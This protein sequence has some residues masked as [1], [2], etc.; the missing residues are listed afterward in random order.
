MR[1]RA[2]PTVLHVDLDAFFASVEQ[3]DDP[4]L[5]GRPVIVGGLGDR[6]VVATASYEARRYGVR[7][8]MP[9]ARA[10]RACPDA[11]FVSPRMQ[12]YA[13]KSRDVMAILG[14]V[15][16]LVEQLS[17][18][19][20]FLDV[21]GAR[22]RLGPPTEIAR[23]VRSR[24]RDETGLTVSVGIATTKF[25]AKVASDL[26]KP[27][28]LLE[29]PAGDET[30]FLAPLPLARLWGAG[31]ATLRKCDRLGLRTIGDLA[32]L[33]EDVV[34]RALGAAQGA[35]L[36]ALAHN[37]D[38]RPVEPRRSAKSVGAEETFGTDLSSSR[39]CERELL[40]LADRVGGRLR[41]AGLTARTVTLKIRFADFETHTRARTLGAPT[42]VSATL[43]DTA[44]D[45]LAAFD[46]SRGVRLL[47]ISCSQFGATPA[48]QGM[49]DL[50]DDTAHA[51]ERTVR[52]AA[53]ER[54]V[55]GV[56]A[57]FGTAAVRPATLVEP[58]EAPAA[59]APS[60][61]PPSAPGAGP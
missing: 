46:T 56:R 48:G 13:Q 52:H 51:H 21:A 42:D 11:V 2:E 32:A 18:D 43:L 61:R 9:M 47:G 29:V 58:R 53:V 45:L 6:G 55:D 28:G 33:D 39:Q 7:S 10:R 27:D 37:R 59:P 54:A 20:A 8:A 31:P 41:G 35:H 36:Y 19:E 16:P 24:V 17:V 25:L 15:T 12:R 3:L 1:S 23:L 49:L 26:A 40:R 4:A 60:P 22:R 14:D 5:R 44:R 50:G 34:V 57:R 30:T 38:P